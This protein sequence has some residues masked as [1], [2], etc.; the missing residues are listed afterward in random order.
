MTEM[1]QVMLDAITQAINAGLAPINTSIEEIKGRL[2]TLESKGNEDSL[3]NQQEGDAINIVNANLQEEIEE[4]KVVEEREDM[5]LGFDNELKKDLNDINKEVELIENQLNEKAVT[6]AELL[7]E[8]VSKEEFNNSQ[9]AI[10]NLEEQI[11]QLMIGN[12]DGTLADKSFIVESCIK[13][14]LPLVYFENKSRQRGRNQVK[15]EIQQASFVKAMQTEVLEETDTDEKRLTKFKKIQNYL[16]HYGAMIDANLNSLPGHALSESLLNRY[17][18]NTYDSFVIFCFQNFNFDKYE[19]KIFD[20]V[21]H[22][23]DYHPINTDTTMSKFFEEWIN[24]AE[25]A[26]F[27]KNAANDIIKFAL[28]STARVAKLHID[29]AAMLRASSLN[30]L[31]D[32]VYRYLGNFL[33]PKINLPLATTDKTNKNVTFNA[34]VNKFPIKYSNHKN[35]KNN[36]Y[37]NKN[38]FNKNNS[39]RRIH[40]WCKACSCANCKHAAAKYNDYKNKKS[41]FN[42]HRKTY[43]KSVNVITE[44]FGDDEERE[45]VTCPCTVADEDNMVSEA[46]EEEEYSKEVAEV[47]NSQTHTEELPNDYEGEIPIPDAFTF[48]NLSMVDK[49][50]SNSQC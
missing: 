10:K 19:K 40:Y 30:D 27:I 47:F 43:N 34:I 1:N 21:M 24:A 46:E 11:K 50:L 15:T 37:N 23:P 31:K 41:K 29:E 25:N 26:P 13:K 2:E 4:L 5:L 17:K 22:Y 14:Y 36:N 8:T 20:E 18:G 33:M 32:I 3:V 42:N 44:T 49:N 9:L 45:E 16:I 39:N 7:A 28:K 38:D 35:Y 12:K 48:A 6:K